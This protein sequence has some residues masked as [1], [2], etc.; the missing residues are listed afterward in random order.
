[1]TFRRAAGLLLL[2]AVGGAALLWRGPRRAPAGPPPGG[3]VVRDALGR[4]VVCPI[5]P[6]R[7]VSLAPSATEML[8]ALGLGERLVGAT[9]FCDYPPEAARLPKIGG[10]TDP[11]LER[12]LSLRPDLVVG[13]RGNP[14]ELFERL[15]RLGVAGLAL[16]GESL[17][18]LSSDLRLLGRAAGAEARAGE[19]AEEWQ[20]RGEAL[21]ALAARTPNRPRVL[22]LFSLEKPISAGAGSHLDDL[23]RRAGGR[24]LAAD[25]G[26]AWPELTRESILTLDPEVLILSTPHGV[27]EGERGA[28]LGVLRRDPRW[29]GVAAVR[30]GRVALL[31][32]D[33]LTIPGP[34]LF[35]GLERMA[36]V[37][38]PEWFGPGSP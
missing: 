12:I 27:A 22:F 25:A 32:D 11:N 6:E 31:D 36:E 17:V 21:A 8:F 30:N 10:F 23:I 3:R 16:E 34:R 38:H 19:L 28:P 20:R 24:N 15:E 7:I 1:M 35:E 29:A 33:L 4:E 13:A 26:G 18:G 9:H 5:R 2:L 14:R 37:I